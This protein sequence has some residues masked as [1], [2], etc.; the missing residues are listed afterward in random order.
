MPEHFLGFIFPWTR[1]FRGLFIF[2]V[3]NAPASVL[4]NCNVLGSSL[5]TNVP[6]FYNL[7]T[8]FILS[9]MASVV[10]AFNRD[11]EDEARYVS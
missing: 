3:V 7:Q 9:V 4:K 1:A 2:L 11:D 5:L 10:T 8:L 6:D